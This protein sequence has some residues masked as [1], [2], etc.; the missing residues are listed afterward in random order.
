M[1]DA[2]AEV[3]AQRRLG[4]DLPD[5]VH[6]PDPLAG[7][8]R[9]RREDPEALDVRRSHDDRKSHADTDL[10]T[11]YRMPQYSPARRGPASRN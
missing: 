3:F 9:S 6:A 5:H 10:N 8:A 7:T 4:G 2:L 11:D 1:L